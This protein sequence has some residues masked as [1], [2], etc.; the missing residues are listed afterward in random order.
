MFFHGHG[1]RLWRDRLYA[2]GRGKG[3]GAAE[4]KRGRI[5][6]AAGNQ[7]Y[8]YGCGVR[9]LMDPSAGV[10][11]SVGEFGWTGMLGSYVSI[12]PAEKL[13]LVYMHNL[14]PNREAYIHP[15]IRNIVYGV[16]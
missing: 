12:D 4:G 10:N 1:Y 15:R 2:S 6:V 11:S 14:F 13:S 16:L 7:G 5:Y 3:A 9:T 8:G